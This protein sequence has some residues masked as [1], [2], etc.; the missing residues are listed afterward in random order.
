MLNKIYL[1]NKKEF[2]WFKSFY[3]IHK[4]SF[5]SLWA[6]KASWVGTFIFACCL[7]ILF[8]FGLGTEAIQRADIQ[9]GTFW[10]MNEFVAVLTI[11]RIFSA[12]Q[13]CNGMDLLLT[14]NLPKTSIIAGKIS[15]TALQIF[16]LQIPILLLWIIFYN[17]NSSILLSLMSNL[18]FVAIFFNLGSASLGTLITCLTARSLAK[19]ILLPMLFFPFQSGILLASVSLTIHIGSNSLLGA[20][21]E[22]AWWTI[23]IAY[24]IIFSTLGILLS[25]LLLQE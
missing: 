7:L 2:S 19:E 11:S 15:F 10:I 3:F 17:I 12:E 25:D 1:L 24:P 13:E 18:F 5:R 21:S 16:T 23:L 14:S 8:P 22:N 9:I 6:R 20:F 4:L